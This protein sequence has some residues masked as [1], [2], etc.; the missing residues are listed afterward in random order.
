MIF[1]VVWICPDNK[2]PPI[3]SDNFI[4]LSRLTFL[5]CSNSFKLVNFRVSAIT[6][7]HKEDF[8]IL[9][10]VR[11]TPSTLTLAPVLMPL[12]NFCDVLISIEENASPDFRILA[13]PVS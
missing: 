11:H 2:W 6:S 7:K 10:T 3:S 8:L 5:E 13:V 12:R 9:V 1:P 4:D